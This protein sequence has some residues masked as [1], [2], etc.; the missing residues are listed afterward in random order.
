MSQ[1]MVIFTGS[2]T[3]RTNLIIMEDLLKLIDRQVQEV[4][5]M[6]FKLN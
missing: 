5:I 4:S 6:L 1:T 2:V 3:R